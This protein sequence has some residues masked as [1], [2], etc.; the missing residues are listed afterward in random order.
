MATKTEHLDFH[1]SE[2]DCMHE[3]SYMYMKMRNNE[4]KRQENRENE[5]DT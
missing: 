2:Y 5:A 1:R 4:E 3:F